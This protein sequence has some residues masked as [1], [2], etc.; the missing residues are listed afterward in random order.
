MEL[1]LIHFLV[2]FLKENRSGLI[3]IPT[4]ITENEKSWLLTTTSITELVDCN[5]FEAD[6]HLIYVATQVDNMPVFIS[7]TDT[8]VLV[9]MVHIYSWRDID[10]PWQMKI[11]HQNFVNIAAISDHI[12]SEACNILPD[13]HS[14][15]GCDTTSFPFRFGIVAS[16]KKL[17]KMRLFDLLST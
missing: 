11:D 8:D 7:T 5:H 15:T 2:T 4:I 3:R 13:F 14:I 17:M 9:L 1:L 16:W 10:Q 6:T 12:S